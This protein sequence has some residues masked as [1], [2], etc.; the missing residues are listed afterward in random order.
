MGAQGAWAQS[1]EPFDLGTITLFGDR[2]ASTLEDSTASVGIVDEEAL[3]SPN[4]QTLADT[5]RRLGNVLAPPTG[6]DGI[7]IRGVN[8]E[9]LVPGGG[10]APVASLYVDGIQQTVNGVRQGARGLFDTE[11][12]EV[13]RGPQSTLTGRNALAG[14]IYVRTKDPEFEPGGRIQLTYGEDN[15]EQIGIAVGGPLN[16][17]LAYRLSGEWFSKDSDLAYPSYLGFPR[18]SDLEREE[19]YQVRGKLLWLPTGSEDTRVLF[20]VSQSFDSPNQ[21]TV[22][23]RVAPGRGDVALPNVTD[24]FNLV[25][26]ENEELRQTEVT[27]LG[28]EF[29]HVFDSGLKF[30]S[31]T[32]YSHSF[33]DRSSINAGLPAQTFFTAGYFDQEATT[34]EFRL[35]FENDRVRWVA[36]LYGAW[37]QTRGVRSSVFR[38]VIPALNLTLPIPTANNLVGKDNN[39]AIFGE[40]AYEFAPRWTV[41]GGGRIDHF[42]SSTGGFVGTLATPIPVNRTF[43]DTVFIP[44]V[45]LSYELS[46]T[47]TL[48][49]VY[50]QGYRPG[51]SFLRQS[52]ATVE[53]FKPEQSNNFELTYRGSLMDDR[54]NVSASVFYQDWQD[55]QVETFVPIPS[56]L[57]FE[58]ITTNAGSSESYGAEIEVTYAATAQTEIFTSVGLLDTRF[59]SLILPPAANPV[60]LAGVNFPSAPYAT[61]ALGADWQ[62]PQGWFAGGVVQYVSS[63]LSTLREAVAPGVVPRLS[64]YVT[65]DVQAGYAFQNGAAVTIYANN[66]F[67]EKYFT[68]LNT[69]NNFGTL[70][71]RREVGVR[72]DY[73]F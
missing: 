4:N 68:S 38:V 39:Y 7:I 43:S 65:V 62:S 48:S 24:P 18:L 47:Q 27:N 6:S 63:Q 60:N 40:V 44:K 22:F 16:D 19:Y 11:Q 66:L 42:E 26:P 25:R 10:T 54:L 5:Y 46:D 14:A 29:S 55:Q 9:G 34:Q 33:T 28:V 13:F 20:T 12:V 35:N 58:N 31:L 3:D 15:R 64:D 70:G 67:D 21:N 53:D 52:T 37:D 61:I 23:G 71:P 73:E 36:G 72:L 69:A 41:I 57:L 32:G 2:S 51:G 30:T 8:S 56:T 1:D 49:F 59:N 45:G 17:R 50:Q